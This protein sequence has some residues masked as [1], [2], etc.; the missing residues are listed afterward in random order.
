MGQTG[1]SDALIGP[2]SCGSSSVGLQAQGRCGYG[3]RL[4]FMVVSPW[5]RTNFVDHTVTDQS[6]PIAFIEKNWSL[7]GPI[8]A[9]TPTDAGS[10]E[11]YASTITNMFDFNQTK[12]E[13]NKHV[14]YLDPTTGAPVK[15]KP[16][17][18]EPGV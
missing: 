9:A 12:G 15:K 4:P 3:P 7:K 16:K 2:D 6:S 17:F 8:V 14:L 5:A 13:V 11:Q 18:V 1:D 10:Y